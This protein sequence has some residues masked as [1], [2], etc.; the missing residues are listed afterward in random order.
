LPE[1]R[2]ADGVT[3]LHRRTNTTTLGWR[4][5]PR[6]IGGS[7]KHAPPRRTRHP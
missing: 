2:D 5:S 1:R 7:T 3:V 6:A 4:R